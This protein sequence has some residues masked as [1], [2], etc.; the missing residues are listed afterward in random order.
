MQSTI[1]LHTYLVD[2]M[3]HLVTYLHLSSKRNDL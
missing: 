1:Y 3:F 2:I